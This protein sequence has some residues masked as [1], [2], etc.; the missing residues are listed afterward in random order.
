MAIGC[1]QGRWIV[2]EKD[3]EKRLRKGIRKMGG[4]CY[5]FVS[6]GNAGVPD[7]IVVVPDKV[8]FVEL[9]TK[10]GRLTKLQ[11]R[12]IEKLK[13]LGSEVF[14]LWGKEDVDRFLESCRQFLKERREAV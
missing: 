8:L 14:V 10:T 3:I 9:K 4:R 1:R 5:K 11:Q 6:P 2:L 12:Q 7:R 13:A